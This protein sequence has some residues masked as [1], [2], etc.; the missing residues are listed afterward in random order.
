MNHDELVARLR[1]IEWQGC[2]CSQKEEAACPACGRGQPLD[3]RDRRI[4]EFYGHKADC[5]LAA[6][7][8]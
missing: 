2:G 8:G 7:I 6:A 4:P 3:E 5:W 1:E